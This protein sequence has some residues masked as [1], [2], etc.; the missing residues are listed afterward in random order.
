MN[1][2]D[3]IRSETITVGKPKIVTSEP[4]K[5]IKIEKLTKKRVTIRTDEGKVALFRERL[6]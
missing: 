1:S 5:E 6:R 4:D 2:S 3:R